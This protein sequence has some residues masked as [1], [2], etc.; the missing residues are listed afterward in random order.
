[1]LQ[2]T[3]SVKPNPTIPAQDLL[4][5]T[6][7][8]HWA[9]SSSSFVQTNQFFTPRH[10]FAA[11]STF[12][13]SQECFCQTWKWRS[14]WKALLAQKGLPELCPTQDAQRALKHSL[15]L[16]SFGLGWFP[17]RE[18]WPTRTKLL[19]L[20]VGWEQRIVLKNQLEMAFPTPYGFTSKAHGMLCQPAPDLF[21]V[22]FY[23]PT[24]PTLPRA[25]QATKYWCF[26]SVL[27]IFWAPHW[28]HCQPFLHSHSQQEFPAAFSHQEWPRN[29][30][31]SFGK[32]QTLWLQELQQQLNLKCAP[33]LG[34]WG[35]SLTA[36]TQPCPSSQLTFH[37]PH[38]ERGNKENSEVYQVLPTIGMR[39]QVPD[40]LGPELNPFPRQNTFLSV[41]V[42]AEMFNYYEKWNFNR[43]SD[44]SKKQLGGFNAVLC[45]SLH[46]SYPHAS[47]NKCLHW[48]HLHRA[49]VW[50]T[51]L[52]A[53]QVLFSL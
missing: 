9:G 46:P 18:V 25:H 38:L 53:T 24:D 44:D 35:T 39:S 43:A 22:S 17:P 29:W 33:E 36:P 2:L 32:G 14:G 13:W 7:L 15:Q 6:P 47:F 23:A 52:L 21:W 10:I 50:G 16:W 31:C 41:L 49:A 27:G 40:I 37:L 28:P 42:I 5:Q 4:A 1:M 30:G 3:I 8:G 26:L 11:A 20:N 51:F 48:E 34:G 19:G 12:S 45:R